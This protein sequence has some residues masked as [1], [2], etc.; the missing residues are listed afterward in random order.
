MPAAASMPHRGDAVPPPP[1]RHD[2]SPVDPDII[3]YSV[4]SP[5]DT[6]QEFSTT[7]ATGPHQQRHRISVLAPRKRSPPGRHPFVQP[8]SA[9]AGSCPARRLRDDGRAHD[10]TAGRRCSPARPAG[11]NGH[12]HHDRATDRRRRVRHRRRRTS[13]R[14]AI[15]SSTDEV[16]D[17]PPDFGLGEAVGCGAVE[18]SWAGCCGLEPE[19][20]FGC[21]GAALRDVSVCMCMFGPRV[22]ADT[23]PRSL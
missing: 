8:G 2:H 20:C 6:C 22:H 23:V 10:A 13:G 3:A 11:M 18:A 16:E 5:A 19:G 9:T 4:C 14:M 12:A 7:S 17:D 21:L 15:C 1:C